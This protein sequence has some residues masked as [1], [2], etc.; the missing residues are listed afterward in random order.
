MS[1]TGMT[2]AV[3]MTVL[4]GSMGEK[5]TFFVSPDTHFTLSGGVPDELKN[6]RGI[7]DMNRLAGQDYPSSSV[8]GGAVEANVRGVVLPGDLVDDGC[9]NITTATDPGCAAEW[10]NYS[11]YFK[12][13]S[14]AVLMPVC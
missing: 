7:A 9:S 12:V 1:T 10:S 5:V 4:A 2:F 8:W 3:L 14:S 11:Y 6:A 13:P